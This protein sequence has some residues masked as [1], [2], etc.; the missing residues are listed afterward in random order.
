MARK[1][2]PRRESAAKAEVISKFRRSGLSQVA[3]CKSEGI[4]VSTFHNWLK[5]DLIVPAAF[6]EIVTQRIPST[7]VELIF[8]DGT[9]L[10]IRGE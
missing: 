9:A 3:F 8:P 5:K 7:T 4:P 6:S 1:G 2:S 10:R